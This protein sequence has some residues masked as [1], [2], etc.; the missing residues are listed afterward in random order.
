M[1]W[2]VLG[3]GG[4]FGMHL[5]RRLVDAQTERVI[6]VGRNPWPAEPWTLGL[7][8]GGAGFDYQQV[9]ILHEPKRLFAL[10]EA[11]N[12]D[13]IVNFA[14]LAYATSWTDADLYYQTNVV[15]LAR[16]TEWLTTKRWQEW[17]GTHRRFIQIGTSEL[18]GSCDAPAS[19]DAPLRPTSPYAVSKMAA[20]LHLLTLAGPR[21][22]PVIIMRP[23]NAYGEGQQL[24]RI[25]TR[26]AWH[27]RMGGKL[28]LQGGGAAQKSYIHARDLARAIASV[29][30]AGTVGEVYN[31]GPRYPVTIRELV[32][33]VAQ[34]FGRR[35]EDIAEVGPPRP[36]EDAKYWLDSSKI[37]GIG[38]RPVISLGEGLTRV[39]AW[40]DQYHNALS[41]P[42]DFV[43]RA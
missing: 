21:G 6:S 23:S 40:I 22:L 41:A 15:A 42:R 27:A 39:K 1:R 34:L 29:A 3:G 13:I 26:A 20:D 12:P 4:V 11:E 8:P 14:A 24:Y 35:I 37:A 10:I 5:A 43:L 30:K 19:E 17:I 18:Y 28:I 16:L 32:D 7:S 33:N 9:H 25:V 2:M 36:G 31:C 38:W